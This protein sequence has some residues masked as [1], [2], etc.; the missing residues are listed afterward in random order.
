LPIADLER[1]S[2]VIGSPPQGPGPCRDLV[3]EQAFTVDPEFLPF[4][5]H[6]PPPS[7]CPQVL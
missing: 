1:S 4:I 2:G 7:K 6:T 5:M 3:I